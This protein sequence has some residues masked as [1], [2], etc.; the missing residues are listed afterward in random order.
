VNGGA[1]RNGTSTSN[2]GN[3]YSEAR[4]TIAGGTVTCGKAG[5]KT[6]GLGGNLYAQIVTIS[7]GTVSGGAHSSTYNAF[8]GGNI[9]V[10]KSFTMSGGTVSQGIAY[11]FGGNLY[12]ETSATTTI[13]GGN[14]VDG[15]ARDNSGGSAYLG[16]TVTM[17]NVSFQ[18]GQGWNGG[19]IY[20][21]ADATLTMTDCTVSGAYARSRGGALYLNNRANATLNNCTITDCTA[22]TEGNA[23]Y[24]KASAV[25]TLNGCTIN[26]SL[27]L[28]ADSTTNLS[29]QLNLKELYL[30][31]GVKL[32]QGAT[33]IQDGSV[34]GISMAAAGVF[35]DNATEDLS[36]L[37]TSVDT[38]KQPVW[39][40]NTLVLKVK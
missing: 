22:K 16:G 34:I 36:G 10:T 6:A 12:T 29:G 11:E 40:N 13:T 35:M 5:S 18:G 4:I 9:Y 31:S 14:F 37:F 3:I 15:L 32:K 33:G 17:S 28:A 24:N 38:A 27:F 25:L 30:A 21:N 2:G 23:V 1:V 7:G 39:E 20:L 19:A 8:R 26:T